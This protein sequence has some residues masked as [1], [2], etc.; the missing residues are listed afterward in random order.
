[1]GLDFTFNRQVISRVVKSLDQ[2]FPVGRNELIVVTREERVSDDPSDWPSF[3]YLIDGST[4]DRDDVA[5]DF[6][7]W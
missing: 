2:L 3:A 7:Q 5:G 4:R 1:M 6:G